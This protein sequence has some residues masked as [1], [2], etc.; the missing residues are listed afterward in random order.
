MSKT[1]DKCRFWD[2]TS[3]KTGE[4]HKTAPIHVSLPMPGKSACKAIWPETSYDDWCGDFEKR[5]N[6]DGNQN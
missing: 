2:D 3:W 1:C 4:C 5:G 6:S